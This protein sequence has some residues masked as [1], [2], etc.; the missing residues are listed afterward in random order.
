MNGANVQ[1]YGAATG[2]SQGS[3]KSSGRNSHC[4]ISDIDRVAYA[5]QLR[6]LVESR[7]N[8]EN[9]YSD[10]SRINSNILNL[11]SIKLLNKQEKQMRPDMAVVVMLLLIKTRT[12]QNISH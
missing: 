8:I 3:N 9:P 4:K 1:I 11:E 5:E 10:V 12:E 7:S 2:R 6:D